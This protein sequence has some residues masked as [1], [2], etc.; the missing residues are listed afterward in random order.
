[1]FL[2]IEDDRSAE[3]GLA[4][5]GPADYRTIRIGHDSGLEGQPRN[6]AR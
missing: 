4:E 5:R 2:A 6:N 3:D 1:V